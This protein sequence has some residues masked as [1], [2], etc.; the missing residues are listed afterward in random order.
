M[1]TNLK[2]LANELQYVLDK[3]VALHSNLV[4]VLRNEYSH[5]S[6]LDTKG[7]SECAHAKEVLLGEIMSHE[8]LRIVAT[9]KFAK[10][11]GLEP[12]TA[13]LLSI[14]A[15][16]PQDDGDVLRQIRTALNLLMQQAK[17]QN[18]KNMGF[19]ESSLERIDQMKRNVLGISSQGSKEN[20]SQSGSRQ[21]LAEQGGRL[22]S[23]EA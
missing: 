7:L 9:E 11:I 16:L 3:L 22:L 4:E 5:M 19:A 12:S 21:P 6:T 2:S 1:D 15:A 17:E 10:A 14:A 23:T 8:Q 20:Y 13:T 18:A